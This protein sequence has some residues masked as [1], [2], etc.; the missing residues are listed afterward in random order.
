MRHDLWLT[1][2]QLGGDQAECF[3]DSTGLFKTILA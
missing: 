3:A 1:L 2:Q